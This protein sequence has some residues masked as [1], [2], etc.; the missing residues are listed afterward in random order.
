[1]VE[2]EQVNQSTAEAL[3][4]ARET[5]KQS[6]RAY[7]LAVADAIVNSYGHSANIVDALQAKKS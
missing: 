7:Y 4:L 3:R 2:R 5:D 1:M 6:E